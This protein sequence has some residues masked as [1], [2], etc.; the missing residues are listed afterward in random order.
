MV[1]ISVESQEWWFKSIIL[2]CGKLRQEDCSEF[3][4]SMDY[5]V[6]HMPAWVVV[7]VTDSVSNSQTTLTNQP[8]KTKHR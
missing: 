1:K 7:T 8:N 5:T 4:T 3:E 2:A 6:N